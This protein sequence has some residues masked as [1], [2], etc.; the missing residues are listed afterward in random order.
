MRKFVPGFNQL[1]LCRSGIKKPPQC[2]GLKPTS[3]SLCRDDWIT[4][5]APALPRSSK[6]GGLKPTRHLVES[7][8]GIF[9]IPP[10]R[11]PSKLGGYAKA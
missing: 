1:R 11:R 9:F 6:M 2:G 8:P 3:S 5:A 4:S 10:L 7:P